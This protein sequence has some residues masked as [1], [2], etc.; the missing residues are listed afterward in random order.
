VEVTL[1]VVCDGDTVG[2]GARDFSGGGET[3]AVAVF[4]GLEFAG[5][6]GGDFVLCAVGDAAELMANATATVWADETGGDGSG[7]VTAGVGVEQ[8]AG[9]AGG[10]G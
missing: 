3:G 1:V 5:G 10:G 6:G 2:A 8:N 9:S 7:A 4:P